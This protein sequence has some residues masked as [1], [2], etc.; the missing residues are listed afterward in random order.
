[1]TLPKEGAIGKGVIGCVFWGLAW[2]IC[3]FKQIERK[4]KEMIEVHLLEISAARW[5]KKA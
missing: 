4:R 2:L 1:M 3:N 5:I